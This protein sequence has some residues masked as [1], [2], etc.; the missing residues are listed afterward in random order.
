MT[1]P[2][3]TV[4]AAA[5]I[6]DQ[7]GSE[8]RENPLDSWASEANKTSTP[9]PTSAP[10]C[11]PNL[12]AEFYDTRPELAHI[13]QAAHARARSADAVLGVVLAR[14][15]A[16]VPPTLRLPAIVGSTATLDVVVALIGHSGSGKSSSADVAAELVPIGGDDVA[17]LALGSGEGLIEAYLD[18]VDEIDEKG[19][20]K[21]AKRQVRRG[22]LA[23]LDEGQAL[24]EM[25]NR[26]GSTLM[27]T[28]RSAWSGGRL[29]Q[30]NASDDRKRHLAA[31]EYR[32]ALVAGFQLEHA[33]ALI[34]D[35]AGGTPQRFLWF[36]A[37][38][39]TIP[40]D[41]PA[42]PDP[43]RW[44]MPRHTVNPLGVD[45]RVANEIRGRAL[46]RSRGVVVVDP[47]DA[48]RDLSRM[49]V[50]GLLA[51]MADRLTID[52]DD[53]R[54]A[55]D[56]LDASDR[57]RTSI[58][59]DAQRRAREKERTTTAGHIRREAAIDDDKVIRARNSMATSLARHVHRN[60]C[61]GGCT[62]R[63]VRHSTA[64]KHRQL[65][66]FDD[67]VAVAVREGWITLDGE[68]IK[69]GKETP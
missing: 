24:A 57:V 67:A 21:Q 7:R 48:H 32:F 33:T 53:W 38:D 14:V 1:L 64:S 61:D 36:A 54:L 31:G 25:G 55:G 2:G 58:V 43:L 18:H 28:I 51:I 52:V 3:N 12:P 16:L 40:D 27:P 42:W 56:V 6:L 66:T 13:R 50:A 63:C 4:A 68:I 9:T 59:T 23:M 35:A 60:Q 44:K 17:V 45:D 46:A 69:P 34:D 8:P 65:A 39:P 11:I 19:K 37:E 26:R 47:L 15:A 41:A 29:G 22:V 5:L 20:I 10:T 30:A 62:R 49:K